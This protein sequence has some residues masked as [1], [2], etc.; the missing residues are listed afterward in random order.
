MMFKLSQI[1]RIWSSSSQ[2]EK[3]IL[4]IILEIQLYGLLLFY[5]Y[6]AFLSLQFKFIA[7]AWKREYISLNFS[8]KKTWSK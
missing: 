8:I 7:T 4:G 2:K 6:S 5:C 1:R 3:V